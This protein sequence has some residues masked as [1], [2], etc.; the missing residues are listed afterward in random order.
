MVVVQDQQLVRPVGGDLVVDVVFHPLPPRRHDRELALGLRGVEQ[1]RLAGHRAR[2]GQDQEALAAG[3]A[4]TDPELL[5]ALL[6]DEDVVGRGG[7]DYVPPHPERPPGVVD[8]GVEQ[9]RAVQRPGRAVE[10]VRYLVGPGLA[11]HQVLDPQR[12]A[13]PAGEVGGVSQQPA[14]GAHAV[15]TD[16]E[17]LPVA[18]QLV[19]VQQHLLAVQRRAVLAYRRPGVVRADGPAAEHR[20]LLALDRPHVVP[21]AALAA[22]HGQVG[23]LGPRLDLAEDGLAKALLARR[24]RLGVGILRLEEGDRLRA[25]LVGQPRVLV[26]ERVAMEGALLADPPGGRRLGAVGGGARW[27]GA[28]GSGVYE[29]PDDRVT[30]GAPDA[31]WPERGAAAMVW[32]GRTRADTLPSPRERP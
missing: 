22:R 24:Q 14:V 4:D 11:G 12:E 10:R 15:G 3:Q 31:S 2:H 18:R 30:A 28:H 8:R 16:R 29:G 19:A 9:R 23:F 6:I 1:P 20:V 21:P 32:S 26:D 7:A 17:E 13:L 25:F 27:L 5:V